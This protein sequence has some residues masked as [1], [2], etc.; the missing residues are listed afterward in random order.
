[1]NLLSVMGP[2]VFVK[3]IPA[4]NRTFTTSS[5]TPGSISNATLSSYALTAG[6]ARFGS[7]S[8]ALFT[9]SQAGVY[10]ITS[11]MSLTVN[12]TGTSNVSFVSQIAQN[13]VGIA[14]NQVGNWGSSPESASIGVSATITA[15]IGDIISLAGL[16]QNGA[17]TSGSINSASINIV[18][19]I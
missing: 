14:S 15:A 1:M 11:Q 5:S 2:T 3:N 16:V 17:F 9:F 7:Q 13:G 4:A 10:A 19:I 18:K 12:F 6:S 8:G